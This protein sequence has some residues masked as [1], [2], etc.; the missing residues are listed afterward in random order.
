MTTLR[1]ACCDEVRRAALEGHATLNGIDDLRVD[2]LIDTELDPFERATYLSLPITRR[3]ALLWQRKLTV[4]FVNP[5]TQTQ[6]DELATSEAFNVEGG[7]RVTD[8][9]MA[10]PAPPLAGDRTVTLRASVAGDFSRYTLR[11]VRSTIDRR[12]PTHIDPVLGHVDFSFKVDCPSEFDCRGGHV[13]L[14]AAPDEPTIDYLAKD[15]ASFRRLILD[16]MALLA[17]DWRE[18]NPA[19]LGVALVE[20][21][22]YAGDHLS[23]QQDAVAT[24]AYLATARRRT[25]VRRHARLVDYAMHDGCN[26]RAWLH[27]E[28]AGDTTLQPGDFRCLTGAPELPDR[29]VP[30]GQDEQRALGADAEWFE[31]VQEDPDPA[32]A[33]KTIPLFADHNSIDFYT[34]GDDRCCLPVGSIGATLL[35]THPTL[36]PGMVL[37]LHEVKGPS[38]GAAVD[39]DPKHRQAV[40]LI[41]VKTLD[42][43]APL[44]DPLDDTP[45]TEITWHDDDALT[46]PLCVSSRSSGGQP[47]TAVSVA[48][49]NMVLVDHGRSI[50]PEPLGTVPTP[51]LSWTLESHDPACHGGDACDSEREPVPARFNPTLAEGPLTMT[52]TVRVVQ[53]K[54]PGRPRRTLRFDASA[55]AAAAL[56]GSPASAR[57]TVVLASDL[58]GVS[59]AWSGV[60]DL[61]ESDTEALDFVVETEHGGQAS[62]RFGDNEHAIRPEPKEAFTASYRIGNGRAGNVGADAI[63]HV[64]TLDG[65]ISRVRN[66]LP[67]S[68]GTEPETV[69]EVRRRAPEAFRTQRRA[70]TPA[71][72]AA[73]T[74][75]H[76]S[77]QRAAA[78]IRWT[79]SWPTMFIT[80]DRHD[81]RKLDE[82]CER[83]LADFVEPYRLAGHDL[84]F[85]DPQ[86]VPLE[87]AL[88][89]CVADGYFRADVKARLLEVLSNRVLPDGRRGL[90]HP[91]LFTFGQPVYLSPILA[92]ARQV[93]GVESANVTTFERQGV[94]E[95]R[96]LDAGRLEIGQL[97][98]AQLENDPDRPESGIL[99]LTLQGGK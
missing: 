31:A 70:V 81:G 49:G 53:Q 63:R 94:P 85:D 79:G 18:R 6:A 82:S 67:A 24:E 2:D 11:L 86:F 56:G 64:I 58:D 96:S 75:R 16:R 14:R 35:G 92:V 25:S 69:D 47:L 37:V 32:V 43:G 59:R 36:E 7:T 41:D 54:V 60:S 42:G 10:L 71:D 30:G 27:V 40:R 3:D 97:E 20:L 84:E 83:D 66:P 50:G 80:V 89:V 90:F 1:F 57:P 88:D 91:D 76:P 19:D 87:V 52:S 48:L 28:V 62:L 29:M 38:T 51:R 26:A 13:C 68:G 12:P 98:V 33:V 95:H 9:R 65:S 77:V 4:R 99:R 17:P 34:W 5:L 23:Y 46:F 8:I 73:V 21:L 61:L 78:A 72:Y 22:A 15:Y 93:T 44:T 55:G 74:G 45:I 39:A